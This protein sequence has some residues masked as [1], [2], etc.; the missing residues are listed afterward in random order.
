MD[1]PQVVGPRGSIDRSRKSLVVP[2]NRCI[3]A[4]HAYVDGCTELVP[5]GVVV[6]YIIPETYND[7]TVESFDLCISLQRVCRR[8]QEFQIQT[9][10]YSGEKL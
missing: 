3:S 10:A 7:P 8:C 9:D 2:V 5:I 6:R 1:E 4:L